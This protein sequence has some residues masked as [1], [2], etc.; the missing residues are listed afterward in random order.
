[1]NNV[2]F[3]T[4]PLLMPGH[5]FRDRDADR[6]YGFSGGWHTQGK[7]EEQ[8]LKDNAAVV[9]APEYLAAT[10]AQRA[11]SAWCAAF[12]AKG[13]RAARMPNPPFRSHS[14]AAAAR[15][16][17]A[18]WTAEQLRLAKLPNGS[19]PS[20][21]ST[22][23]LRDHL[24]ALRDVHG[25]EIGS[26]A[27][28]KIMS[29][30]DQEGAA[31]IQ[32]GGRAQPSWKD[33]TKFWDPA[34]VASPVR[35]QLHTA[36]HAQALT[37]GYG[38]GSGVAQGRPGEQDVPHSEL[39]CGIY[40]GITGQSGSLEA[41]LREMRLYSHSWR[42]DALTTKDGEKLDESSMLADGMSWMVFILRRIT[43]QDTNRGEQDPSIWFQGVPNITVDIERT[44]KQMLLPGEE[45]PGDGGASGG[46]SRAADGQPRLDGAA[47]GKYNSALALYDYMRRYTPYGKDLVI[48]LPDAADEVHPRLDEASVE[49]AARTCDDYKA[50]DPLKAAPLEAHG[51][52]NLNAPPDSV[53]NQLA[54]AMNM[55]AVTEIAG[56][57]YMHAGAPGT[58]AKTVRAA[59]IILDSWRYSPGGPASERPSAF[60]AH[61]LDAEFNETDIGV[62]RAEDQY[63]YGGDI[64][65]H[66]INSE[67]QAEQVARIFMERSLDA[68]QLSFELHN[69]AKVPDPFEVIAVE[70]PALNILPTERW[71]VL[72][73][74]VG[75][76]RAR[77][78]AMREDAELFRWRNAKSFTFDRLVVPTQR[79]VW[80]PEAPDPAGPAPEPGEPP[81]P[82]GDF[83][84]TQGGDFIIQQGSQGG[85]IQLRR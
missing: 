53:V 62:R 63:T 39:S 32:V 58:V 35:R 48:P 75:R 38:R 76:G 18:N 81:R 29:W 19:N 80:D 47:V 70:L 66:F 40:Y 15:P 17:G 61:Y 27:D 23:W 77:V 42:S 60:R 20:E 83:L 22:V 52:V 7:S 37:F 33:T 72:D 64:E 2:R 12:D 43:E 3:G 9:V 56:R 21:D 55:G 44:A 10:D 13:V 54:M 46:W 79:A 1:M 11:S 28:S 41:L 50:G 14:R 24:L 45:K 26:R 74:G 68:H 25:I 78:T 57:R 84:I 6:S 51:I 5:V 30:A 31:K 16:A 65:L 82:T 8:I 85:L 59:D 4:Q 69:L 36:Y 73:V 49:R 67:R 71:R 34:Y